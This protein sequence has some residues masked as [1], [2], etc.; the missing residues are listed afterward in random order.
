MLKDLIKAE[1]RRLGFPLVGV[2]TPDAPAMY[3][4]YEAWLAA[5]HHAAM[6]YLETERA[7]RRRANPRLILP[8]ARSILVLAAP[9][10]NPRSASSSDESSPRGRVASYAWGDD[11]HEVL[12]KRMKSLVSF[13]EAEVGRSISHRMYT[14]TGPVLERELAS[15]AGLGWIGKNA[16]LIHPRYGSYLFLAE[17]FMDVDLEPDSPF[18]EDRCGTCTRCLDACPTQAILPNRTVDSTRCLSYWTIEARGEIPEEIRPAMGEWVFG[19]DI[20]Q[21]VCPWNRAPLGEPLEEFLPRA[22]VPRPLLTEEMSLSPQEFNRK[23]KGSAVKRAKRRG[24]LRNV[25]IVL[26]NLGGES[27]RPALRRALHD[28]DP[29]VRESAQ[30]ALSTLR[31][32]ETG[33]AE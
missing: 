14:D 23:F 5:G 28:E 6:H 7:R 31:G 24:Y 15:R 16:C 22:G 9:Y 10:P 29:F 33:D 2:T 12:P 19:C 25:A 13:I 21:E 1:A 30:R 8:E 32:G 26:G 20:C 11:Y 27:A 3:P 18:E 17:I 4:V